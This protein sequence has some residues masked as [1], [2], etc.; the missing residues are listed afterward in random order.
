MEKGKKLKRKEK[1]E[2]QRKKNRICK[3]AKKING[4]EGIN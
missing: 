3:K 4:K 2:G 1:I